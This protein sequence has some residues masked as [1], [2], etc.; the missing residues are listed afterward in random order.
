[1]LDE[2][3][4]VGA[5]WSKSTQRKIFLP[6]DSLTSRLA[7]AKYLKKLFISVNWTLK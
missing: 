4:L 3:T 5:S 7:K 2:Q 6:N 1:M